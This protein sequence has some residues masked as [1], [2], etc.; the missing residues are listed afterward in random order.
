M[1]NGEDKNKTMSRIKKINKK[2]I[3]D[4]VSFVMETADGL[5]GYNKGQDKFKEELTEELINKLDQAL[6][7]AR[8]EERERIRIQLDSI[9]YTK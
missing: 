4:I 5:D 6:T 2:V 9:L 7:Q 3:E 1:K 8:A